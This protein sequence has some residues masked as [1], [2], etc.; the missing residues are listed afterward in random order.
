M[1]MNTDENESFFSVGS[2]E[3]TVYSLMCKRPP[4]KIKHWIYNPL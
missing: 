2:L 1:R 4:F 3:H